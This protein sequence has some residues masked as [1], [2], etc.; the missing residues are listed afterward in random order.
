MLTG[1]DVKCIGC[2]KLFYVPAWRAKV[3]KGKWCSKKCQWSH[4]TETRPCH[5]CGK[6][7]TKGRTQFFERA[8]C[9]R[10]CRRAKPEYAP[11]WRGGRRFDGKYIYLHDSK[12]PH[13]RIAEHRLVMEKKLGRKLRRLEDVHHLNENKLDNRPENLVIVTRSEHMRIHRRKW[14]LPRCWCGQFFTEG[15]K[16]KRHSAR[17]T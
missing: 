5:H 2:G 11:K 9:S 17:W 10:K 4:Q 13:K 1:K 12:R 16:C 14:K 8:F 7:I 6:S 3:G 15:E